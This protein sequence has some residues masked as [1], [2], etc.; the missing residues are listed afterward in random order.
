MST[1]IS[2]WAKTRKLRAAPNNWVPH[3]GILPHFL[4]KAKAVVAEPP[5]QQL[6]QLQ[7]RQLRFFHQLPSGLKMEVIEHPAYPG[8]KENRPTLVFLHGSYHAAW[9]WALHWLPFF[10]SQGYDCFALS[11]LGQGQSDTPPSRVG[12]TLQSHARDVAH[13]IRSRIS[14]PPVLVGHSFGGLI[15][16]QYLVH[17]AESPLSATLE[18]WEEPYPPLT[19]AVLACSVPPTGN[20]PLVQRYLRN[21]PIASIKVTLS[22]AAK[23][24]AYNE[25]LCKETFFSANMPLSLVQVYQKLLAKSSNVPLFNLKELNA[26]LP[27]GDPVENAPPILVIGAENDF[28]V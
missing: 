11:F 17:V 15:V 2:T 28:V 26:S 9:C 1:Q 8:V 25:S 13:F 18:G 23:L 6:F 22:F 16:Q 12:G 27:V 3:R 24:F 10:A 19:G 14:K 4:I 20:G 7:E 21:K 5:G